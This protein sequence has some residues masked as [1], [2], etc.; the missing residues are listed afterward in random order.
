MVLLYTDDWG[1]TMNKPLVKNL[2]L[3]GIPTIISV[4]GIIMTLNKLDKYKNIFVVVSLI[5][6]VLLIIFLVYYSKQEKNNQEENDTLKK[7]N[8]KLKKTISSMRKMLDINSKTISSIDQL[9]EN[10]NRDINKIANAILDDGSANEKDWD[11]EKIYNDIC[12]CCKDSISKFTN[13]KDETDMSVSFIKY[14]KRNE[15]DYIRMVAHSSP[16]TAK[17]DIYDK[18]QTLSECKY[19]FG[20]LIRDKNRDIFAL[21]DNAKIMQQFYK[22]KP[23]TDLTKYNQYI[24]MPIMCSKN[25]ILGILQITTKYKYTIMETDIDLKKFS[26]TYLTPFVELLILTEKIE[27]GLFARPNKDI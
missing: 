2:I 18:E 20:R 12:V 17:P 3:I 14:Y 22:P 25:K 4:L 10:W 6:L 7:E 23:E 11:C 24:A 26:E 5:L 1:G 21:E 15:N 8:D 16:Q 27:K 9:L 13:L 19:L